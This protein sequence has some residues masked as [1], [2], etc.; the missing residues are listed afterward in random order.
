MKTFNQMVCTVLAGLVVMPVGMPL[1]VMA[2]D[3]FA[4]T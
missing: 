1:M 4:I 3:V 2:D